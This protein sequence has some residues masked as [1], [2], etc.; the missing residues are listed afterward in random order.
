MLPQKANLQQTITP[1]VFLPNNK[2]CELWHV[3]YTTKCSRLMLQ[4]LKI[5]QVQNNIPFF[6]KKICCVYVFISSSNVVRV[7]DIGKLTIILS[8]VI[9]YRSEKVKRDTLRL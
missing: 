7:F 2:F 1:Q 5:S 8:Q 6:K 4:S 9:F 3:I